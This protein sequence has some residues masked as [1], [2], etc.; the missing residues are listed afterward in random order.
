[1]QVR[2]HLR[3]FSKNKIY[4]ALIKV[5]WIGGYHYPSIYKDWYKLQERSIHI[6]DSTRYQK[7]FNLTS[8]VTVIRSYCRSTEHF[9]SEWT[10]TDQLKQIFDGKELERD[11]YPSEFYF[12]REDN[13]TI[14]FLHGFSSIKKEEEFTKKYYEI[15]DN[16]LKTLLIK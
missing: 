11:K 3:N 12:K 8:E 6:Y 15:K 5:H 2:H 14:R 7:F 4:Y 16:I 10:L 13:N 1:M 9:V